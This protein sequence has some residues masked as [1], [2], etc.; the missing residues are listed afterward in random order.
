MTAGSYSQ[1][2]NL[3]TLKGNRQD[4]QVIYDQMNVLLDFLCNTISDA[5]DI[6]PPL[7]CNIQEL[8][9]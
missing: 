9:T 7:L 1:R 6:P 8:Q 2:L 5:T 4:A 3:Q